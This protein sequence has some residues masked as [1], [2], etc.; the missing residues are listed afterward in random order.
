[1]KEEHNKSVHVG[2]SGGAKVPTN[3]GNGTEDIILNETMNNIV[4]TGWYLTDGDVKVELPVKT[5]EE[6]MARVNYDVQVGMNLAVD[7]FG[8]AWSM[9]Q[10]FG[11]IATLDQF[12][13]VVDDGTKKLAVKGDEMAEQARVVHAEMLLAWKEAHKE[14]NQETADYLLE[15]LSQFETVMKAAANPNNTESLPFVTAQVMVE[16]LTEAFEKFEQMRQHEFSSMNDAL[17]DNLQIYHEAFSSF[18]ATFTEVNNARYA[19]LKEALGLKEKLD[20]AE[21]KGTGKGLKFEDAVSEQLTA[22]AGNFGDTLEDIGNQTDGIGNSKV[23][24]HLSTIMHGAKVVGKIVFEDKSGQTSIGGASGLVSQ[25]NQAMQHYGADAGI[26]IVNSKRAPARLR[27]A[28]YL[29]TSSN[30]Y[31][32]CVDWDEND[33]MILDILYPIVREIVSVQNTNNAGEDSGI[34]SNAVIEICEEAL[35][36]LKEL[37]K[38]R[39][40]LHNNAKGTL[41]A[42]AALEVA[43]NKFQVAFQRLISLHKEDSE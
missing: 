12:Q 30:T 4:A 33:F 7:F 38:L 41:N 18:V 39:L 23:G 14:G 16:K 43:Q 19:A 25:L 36:D 15:V 11:S 27:K 37:N 26:G 3:P 13:N 28:G 34:D 31:I 1:M 17:A 21:D 10:S 22:I 24:D 20:Q 5:V 6:I 32:V 40:N 8:K 35:S 9:G 29:R 2:G 42:A